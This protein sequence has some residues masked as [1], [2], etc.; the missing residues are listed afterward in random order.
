[1][2]ITNSN[3]D[4]TRQQVLGQRNAADSLCG[5]AF[6]TSIC[7]WTMLTVVALAAFS[8]EVGYADS[9]FAASTRMTSASITRDRWGVAHIHGRT[10]ADA[11]FGMGYAQAEDY[12]W[13]LEDTCIQ[14]LGRY[15]EI[16]GQDGIRSDILNR[17]FE[18]PR[19]SREDFQ[20]LKP[21][22]QRMATASADGINH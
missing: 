15:A 1:M 22:Y 4:A 7:R 14:S 18:I 12:F 2:A 20:E 16:N 17:S 13:Q 3:S 8:V 6:E 10:H 21:E 11:F 19:R 5:I 9:R